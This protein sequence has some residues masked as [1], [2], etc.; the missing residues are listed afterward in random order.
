MVAGDVGVQVQ[1]DGFDRIELRRGLR[2]EWDAEK[3][4][5]KVDWNLSQ[6]VITPVITHSDSVVFPGES[7]MCGCSICDF[8][9]FWDSLYPDACSGGAPNRFKRL[10]FVYD[11]MNRRIETKVG[12]CNTGT[13]AYTTTSRQRFLYDVW[14]LLLGLDALNSDAVL[15]QY[16]WGLDLG[17]LNGGAGTGFSGTGFQPVS[18]LHATGGISG[19]LAIDVDAADPSTSESGDFWPCHDARGNV[20]RL[21]GGDTSYCGETA[22]ERHD[23]HVVGRC[24]YDP[25]GNIVHSPSAVTLTNPI[26]FSTKYDDVERG[27]GYWGNRYYDPRPGRWVNT[28]SIAEA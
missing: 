25:Y 18:G 15:R 17:G 20:M 2:F 8:A 14:N 9:R 22:G 3:R 23:D 16:T 10:T 13:P 11:Y 19:P 4:L 1:P 24:E 26:R 27:F 21:L 7:R 28:D 12:I 5:M 6:N